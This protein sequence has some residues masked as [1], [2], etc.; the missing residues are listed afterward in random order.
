MSKRTTTSKPPRGAAAEATRTALTLTGLS[1]F[2]RQGF[3][4]TSTREIAAAANA[5]I[6][7]IAYHFGGK[8]GLREAVAD[9]IVATIQ[10]IAAQAL[11][12]APKPPEDAAGA[13]EQLTSAIHNM[14]DFV[15]VQPEAGDIVQFILREMAQPSPALDRIYNGVF[16]PVH[17][18]LC[19]IWELA[20][21][22]PAES[23]RTKLTVFTML[24][25]IIYFRIGKEAVLRRMGWTD[26][27][28]REAGMIT[29]AARDNLN[30]II[31]SRTGGKS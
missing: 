28:K 23:D 18:R 9:H 15:V 19:A 30:A 6:G 7:S 26:I 16:D 31:A 24:G 10:M 25:Q 3:E 4:G 22:E 8:D 1:L 17:R 27:G 21:G 20:T 5:N 29:E 14:V 11:E 2:G 13:Q 12:A